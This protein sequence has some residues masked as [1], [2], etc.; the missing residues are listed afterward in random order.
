M[1]SFCNVNSSAKYDYVCVA[2]NRKSV[3]VQVCS[4]D[5][6]YTFHLRPSHRKLKTICMY[7][8]MYVRVGMKQIRGNLEDK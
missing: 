3:Y 5:I 2:F 4:F 6:V 8:C 1:H 7:L